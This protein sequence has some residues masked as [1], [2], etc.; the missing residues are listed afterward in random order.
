[1]KYGI[2]NHNVNVLNEKKGKLYVCR[3]S[4]KP[5]VVEDYLPCKF[6][7]SFCMKKELFRHCE[8]ASGGMDHHYASD[9]R[10]ILDG[11]TTT[12]WCDSRCVEIESSE[13]YALRPVDESSE[14]R[15]CYIAIRQRSRLQVGPQ[16]V[17]WRCPAHEAISQDFTEVSCARSKQESLEMKLRQFHQRVRIW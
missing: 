12:Q 9:G 1:M 2:F 11:S 4:H 8:L 7:I 13:K 15:C 17:Q 5:H 14:S 6:C 10:L 16:K 3:S